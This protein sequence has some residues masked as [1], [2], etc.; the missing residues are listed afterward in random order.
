MPIVSASGHAY[1]PLFVFPG[2]QAHYRRLNGTTQT[3]HSF[4]PP[5]YI[6]QR[7]IPGVNSA[8]FLDWARLFLKETEHLRENGQYNVL[9]LDG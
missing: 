1:K 7:D 8:I 6:Y 5:S 3:L 9:I 4:L 2:K